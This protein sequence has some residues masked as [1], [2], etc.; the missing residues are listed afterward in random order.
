MIPLYLS[1]GALPWCLLNLFF[2]WVG[3]PIGVG[4]FLGGLIMLGL[5]WP[6][7]LAVVVAGFVVAFLYDLTG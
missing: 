2:I 4:R 7:L 1:I 6:I 5:F 3:A